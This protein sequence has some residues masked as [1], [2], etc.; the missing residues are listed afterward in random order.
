MV[1]QR[2][3]VLPGLR[4]VRHAKTQRHPSSGNR[5]SQAWAADDGGALPCP[6]RL[7]WRQAGIPAAQPPV[8]SIHLLQIRRV[9]AVQRNRKV[10]PELPARAAPDSG[11]VAEQPAEVV[12]DQWSP[13]NPDA[14][15]GAQ[16]PGGNVPVPQQRFRWWF[17]RPAGSAK[18]G[19]TSAFW[20]AR[21]IGD[22]LPPIWGDRPVSPQARRIG[23]RL[24]SWSPTVSRAA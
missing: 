14:P 17:S 16:P 7:E 3:A 23:R 24:K 8:S 12:T 2:R 13:A 15:S 10:R 1:D 5:R 19:K 21:P 18:A 22:V 4:V 20:S 6:P 9:D 11:L